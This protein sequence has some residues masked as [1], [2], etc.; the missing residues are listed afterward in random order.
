ME[1]MTD[2]KYSDF[3]VSAGMKISFTATDGERRSVDFLSGGT[4]DMAY[5]AVRMALIDMLCTEKPPVCFDESFAYQD[6]VRAAAMMRAM[7]KL[8]DDEGMQSFI[9]TCRQREANLAREA[10]KSAAVFKL[11]TAKKKA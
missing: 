7:K 6:N 9:F 10:D 1:I 11:S 2:K 5:I 4:Q 3:G 8:A